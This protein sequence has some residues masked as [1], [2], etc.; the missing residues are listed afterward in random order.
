MKGG[1]ID[2]S[3][4]PIYNLS[5]LFLLKSTFADMYFMLSY[6]QEYTEQNVQSAGKHMAEVTDSYCDQ[7]IL[8]LVHII[9]LRPVHHFGFTL[10]LLIRLQ[11]ELKHLTAL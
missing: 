5:I 1:K 8:A 3:S 7:A 11:V 9:S 2:Q 4:I 6:R 10:T